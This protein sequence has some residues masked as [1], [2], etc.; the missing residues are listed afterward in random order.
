VRGIQ[1]IQ[2]RPT[3]ADPGSAEVTRVTL[4][5]ARRLTF[6][7]WGR[8]SYCTACV[9]GPVGSLP[10]SRWQQLGPPRQKDMMQRSCLLGT[11]PQDDR[12]C[13]AISGSGT[14]NPARPDWSAPRSVSRM[15]ISNR[16]RS[17]KSTTSAKN[18][19]ISPTAMFYWKRA[20]SVA[21]RFL[22]G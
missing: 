19:T 4:T 14:R 13:V 3:I 18:P 8:L 10:K 5:S 16:P 22:V 6:F 2:F 20:Y 11:R 7:A 15:S 9:A 21:R 17:G 1:S 12:P